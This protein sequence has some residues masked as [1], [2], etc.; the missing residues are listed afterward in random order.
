MGELTVG[1][2]PEKPGDSDPAVR[3]SRQPG[4]DTDVCVVFLAPG[5]EVTYGMVAADVL[6][7]LLAAGGAP[8]VLRV[9]SLFVLDQNGYPL[10]QE[11]TLLGLAPAL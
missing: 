5:A 10:Q 1:L 6:H 9:Q 11:L 4:G 7:A 2:G 3:A 8:C